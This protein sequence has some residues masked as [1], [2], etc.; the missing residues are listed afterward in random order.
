MYFLW[1]NVSSVFIVILTFLF[2][3]GI[4]ALVSLYTMYHTHII[5]IAKL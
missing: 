1:I 4:F 5:F 2:F 3:Q